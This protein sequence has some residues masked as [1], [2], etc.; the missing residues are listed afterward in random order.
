MIDIVSGQVAS[1][2]KSSVV[3][4]VGGVGLRVNVPK[5]V[6]DLV[7][8]TG[9]MVMLYT[10]LAVRE[11][12][13]TL[14]GFTTEEERTVFEALISVSGIGPKLALSI[15][16]SLSIDHLR[17]AVA[18]EEPDILTRVPGI[19]KKT[20]E[21]I[22]FELKGK[23]GVAVGSGLAAFA[24]TDGDVIEALTSMGYSIVEAQSA[25]QSL[26]RDAPKDLESRIFLALQ[27]FS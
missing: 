20:A 8:G 23:M 12:A 1:I 19:G 17:A 6:F 27:Y 16:G 11:D 10:H 4:M 7:H 13:L 21:K 25:I 22:I 2:G 5:T 24:D 3:V 14:Y 18:R 9:D 26:P 15:M